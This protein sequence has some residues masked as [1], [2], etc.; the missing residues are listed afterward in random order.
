MKIITL[1]NARFNS[2][3]Q[4]R[5]IKWENMEKVLEVLKT[6]N[7]LSFDKTRHISGIM[8]T[9]SCGGDALLITRGTAK[10]DGQDWPTLPQEEDQRQ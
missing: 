6:Q 3:D 9:F 8:V 2:V 7:F 1:E 10:E 5:G 4:F